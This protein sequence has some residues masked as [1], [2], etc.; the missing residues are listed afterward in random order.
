MLM[1]LHDIIRKRIAITEG[2]EVREYERH[3]RTT[4]TVHTYFTH[5]NKVDVYNHLRQG[6]L[7]LEESRRTLHALGKAGI[8]NPDGCN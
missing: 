4:K 2:G 7:A 1:L 8:S 6:G 3:I 5:A